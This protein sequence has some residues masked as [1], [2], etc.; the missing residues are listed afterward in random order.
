MIDDG[1]GV[2]GLKAGAGGG[3]GGGDLEL[4]SEGVG[5][6]EDGG[7]PSEPARCSRSM[8]WPVVLVPWR[9]SL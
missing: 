6:D 3:D 2:V 9:V 1:D 7:P 4:L 5:E 8:I